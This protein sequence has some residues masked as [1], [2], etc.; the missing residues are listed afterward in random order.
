MIRSKLIIQQIALK[1]GLYGAFTIAYWV[2]FWVRF[3]SGWIPDRMQMEPT[4]YLLL[5]ILSVVAFGATCRVAE[6]DQLWVASNRALWNRRNLVVAAA[7]LMV[8]FFGAFFVRSY[9]FSRLF[10]VILGFLTLLLTS[11]TPR[12]LLWLSRRHAIAREQLKILIVGDGAYAERVAERIRENSWVPCKVIG[13]LAVG[14]NPGGVVRRL[15]GVEDLESVCRRERLDEILVALSLAQLTV[16]P[17]LR[18]TL[19]RVP[20][21][22]R[23][24]CDFLSEVA[25]ST[26]V[27]EVFGTSVVDLHRSPAD[28]LVYA[29]LKRSFDMTVSAGLLLL[30]APVMILVAFLIKLSSAGPVFFCQRRVSLHGRVFM[31]YKFRTMRVQDQQTA[32]LGRTTL[33]D[34]R[35]TPVGVFLR[36]LNLDELPQLWNVLCGDMSLVGPRPEV[37]HYVNKY[38]E[39]V[40]KYNARHFLRSGITGWAQVN[41]W[42][43]QTSIARRIECDLYYL[44]NWSFGFDLK[45]L[46]LTL[47]RGFRDRNAY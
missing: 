25:S 13:Y 38:A 36:R 23:L 30:L 41:G 16:V 26:T 21:P 15:G 18:R 6:L 31:M 35:C 42:R 39:E 46:W 33:N 37:P 3:R 34:E 7:T 14:D 22:S 1:A 4:G 28:S 32:D 40:E 8:V 17:E 20:V 47:W 9:T 27:F 12:L 43:G 44:Q 10:V 5:F 24:V 29:L 19:A 45:I 11:I 2:A